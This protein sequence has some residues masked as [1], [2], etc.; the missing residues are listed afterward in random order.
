MSID[1][2]DSQAPSQDAGEFPAPGGAK[3]PSN[4]REAISCLV[5]SKVKIFQIE[6]KQAAGRAALKIGLLVVATFCFMGAWILLNAGL[7]GVLS[8]NSEWSWY[9]VTLGAAGAH[10]LIG[11][12]LFLIVRSK[13]KEPFP[14]TRAELE[15]DRKWLDQLKNPS[16]SGN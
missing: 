5:C 2:S 15:K 16:N 9:D 8:V 13:S 3:M 6:A 4:W 14:V 10:L 1:S 12:L 7:I 11:V